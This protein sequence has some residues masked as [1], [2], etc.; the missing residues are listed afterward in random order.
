MTTDWRICKE[1]VYDRE[2]GR[3]T[4]HKAWSLYFRGKRVARYRNWDRCITHIQKVY[5]KWPDF[6]SL[7]RN[8]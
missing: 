3:L 4:H 2:I 5:A 6:G 1:R 8:A 7:G